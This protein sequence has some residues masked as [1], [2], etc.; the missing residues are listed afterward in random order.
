MYSRLL[1][2]TVIA[3]AA[4]ASVDPTAAQNGQPGLSIPQAPIGHL[5][6]RASHFAPR[7]SA[8]Q[9]EQDRMSAFDAEQQKLDQDLDRRLN[10]CRRC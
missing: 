7:S 2:A 6:P 1:A 8:E 9:V 4:L 10:I 5:Q 3:A